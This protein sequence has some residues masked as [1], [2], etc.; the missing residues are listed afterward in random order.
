LICSVSHAIHVGA[1]LH[2]DGI[3]VQCLSPRQPNVDAQFHN[4]F[5]ELL[6]DLESQQ[7][8][9]LLKLLWS[10]LAHPG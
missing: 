6:K 1:S 2:L 9:I 5:Q 4:V 8:L 3:K 10:R 7:S